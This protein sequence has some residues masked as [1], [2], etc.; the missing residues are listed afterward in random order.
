MKNLKLHL[1]KNDEEAELEEEKV[2]EK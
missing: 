2:G 1:K